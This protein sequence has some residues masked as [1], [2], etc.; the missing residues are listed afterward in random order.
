[1]ASKKEKKQEA[2]TI[3]IKVEWIAMAVLFIILALSIFTQG[4]SKLPFNLKSPFSNLGNDEMSEDE[5]KERVTKY[6]NEELLQGQNAASITEIIKDEDSGLYKIKLDIGGQE[7]ES[8]VSMDGKYLYTERIEIKLSDEVAEDYPKKDS[9]DVLLF[10]MS[11]C[12][13]GNQAED[14]VKPV[15]DLLGDNISFEP[16][17]V[18]YGSA[19]GYQGEEYCLDS[20][21][22]Y[23]SMHGIQEL[24][25]DVREIC[26]WKYQQDKYW[27][28]VLAANEKCDYKNVDECWEQV[29]EDVGVDTDKIKSCQSNEAT[30]LLAEEVRLNEEYSVTGSPALFI[31]GKKYEGQRV[32]ENFKQ[33]ICAAF[34]NQP[35]SCSETLDES[36]S[37]PSGS[38]N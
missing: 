8:F 21:N 24:N 3:S 31:N 10:T 35:G 28:F 36:G 7:Y 22:K 17:Y 34:N 20:E 16:H 12:P 15:D 13:Y 11:Y 27:D 26:T 4:F 30:D 18:I 9:P 5:V 37:A 2:Q 23:C 25:Q 19:Q 33:A 29:A 6:I 32:A 38:C 14:F 1:M